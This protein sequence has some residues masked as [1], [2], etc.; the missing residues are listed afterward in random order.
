[1]SFVKLTSLYL[2]PEN[3]GGTIIAMKVKYHAFFFLSL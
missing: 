3:F 2:N 1:M